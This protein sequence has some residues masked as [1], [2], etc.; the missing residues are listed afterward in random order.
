VSVFAS[1]TDTE[2]LGSSSLAALF[3]VTFVRQIVT[4]ENAV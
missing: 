4:I 1:E 3:Q 2:P